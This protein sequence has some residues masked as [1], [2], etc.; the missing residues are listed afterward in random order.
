MNHRDPER[1]IAR[2]E[3]LAKVYRPITDPQAQAEAIATAIRPLIAAQLAAIRVTRPLAPAAADGAMMAAC[4]ALGEAFDS[5]ER[6]KF[7]N[8]RHASL[9]ALKKL[10]RAAAKVRRLAGGG[11]A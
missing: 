8:G 9:R 1:Q 3:V 2:A 11:D 5:Y 7:E 6:S 10:E 4:K